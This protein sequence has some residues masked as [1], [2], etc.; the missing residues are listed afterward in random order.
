MTTKIYTILT[1]L[2]LFSII[3]CHD[4]QNKSCSP[5]GDMILQTTG[6]TTTYLTWYPDS[7]FSIHSDRASLRNI[8]DS[9]LYS[10]NMDTL[11]LISILAT[12]ADSNYHRHKDIHRMKYRKVIYLK[13]NSQNYTTSTDTSYWTISQDIQL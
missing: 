10:S 12:A 11:Y 8:I 4:R 3:S 2:I 13:L 6:E 9:G 1:T 7:I 5:C